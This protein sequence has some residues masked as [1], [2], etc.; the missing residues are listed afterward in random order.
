MKAVQ[1]LRPHVVIVDDEDDLCELIALRLEHHGYRVSIRRSAAETLELLERESVDAVLLDIRL[2]G[3]NGLDLLAEAQRRVFDVPMLVLTA[4]GS[5]ETAVEATRV[6]AFGFMTKPFDDRELL[7]QLSR[8]VDQVRVRR[9]ASALRLTTPHQ[10]ETALV[11]TAGRM[12]A[13]R[14]SIE[15]VAPSDATV[16][17]LGESG[18]GKELA[19]RAIHALSGRTGRFVAVNCA[20][21]PADLLESELFGYRRG[22]FTGAMRD[23]E[24]LFAAANGGTLFL[25]EIGDAPLSIQAKLLRALQEQTY[26]PIGSV[27]PCRSDAR[28]VAATNRDLRADIERGQFREDLFYRLHVFPITMPPLRERREDLPLL[29]ELLLERTATRH[30]LP[31]M[32]FAPSAMNVVL[33]HDW[34]GNVRELANVIEGAALLCTDGVLS[35][36]HLLAVLA[37]RSNAPSEGAEPEASRCLRLSPESSSPS[38]SLVHMLSAWGE[39]P[40][41]KEARAAFERAYLTDVLKR[42][43]GNITSA[44]RMAA[45]NRTDFYDLLR[46]Y[47]LNPIDFR[48]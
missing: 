41:F 40:S 23:K 42:A 3:E 2:D 18:T 37:P 46:R 32:Q 21:L 39:L 16:L 11:G 44:A 8:A 36:H 13:V 34:P 48:Q 47:G 30:K 31:R 35:S 12:S 20:A 45:R 15:R 27:E 7:T 29:A 26:L 6:G 33:G 5:I 22:A 17:I 14:V 1:K 9:E 25:D 24:G 10:P 38:A 43:S 19:A 4:H 28:I